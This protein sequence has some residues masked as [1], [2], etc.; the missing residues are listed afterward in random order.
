M[1]TVKESRLRVHLV[2]RR[3]K[4]SYLIAEHQRTWVSRGSLFG[5]IRNHRMTSPLLYWPAS[6]GY[7]QGTL[8]GTLPGQMRS[9][10]GQSDTAHRCSLPNVSENERNSG[11]GSW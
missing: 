4:H 11:L 10:I 9:E 1:A 8:A 3:S 2:V 6:F 7:D 5:R